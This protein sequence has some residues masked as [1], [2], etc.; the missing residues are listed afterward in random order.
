MTR[1]EVDE[2]GGPSAS[3]VDGSASTPSTTSGTTDLVPFE[4][5]M[6][7]NAEILASWVRLPAHARERAID[8]HLSGLTETQRFEF[9]TSLWAMEKL[10][11]Q[12]ISEYDASENRSWGDS[13][14][15]RMAYGIASLRTGQS[16]PTWRE[17]GEYLRLGTLVLQEALAA[18]NRYY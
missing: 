2:H 11:N 13:W 10:L 17:E 7:R 12:A 16:D 1:V 6:V 3:Q 18:T 15:D 14:E 4:V 8:E 9:L 5:A